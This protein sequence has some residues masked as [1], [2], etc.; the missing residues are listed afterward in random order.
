M[1]VISGLLFYFS[2]QKFALNLRPIFMELGKD[3]DS[4]LFDIMF[5]LEIHS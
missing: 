1:I 3:V 4:I 5:M 2:K